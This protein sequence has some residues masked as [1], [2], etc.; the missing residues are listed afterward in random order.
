MNDPCK[1][2]NIKFSKTAKKSPFLLNV[3]NHSLPKPFYKLVNV[4]CQVIN[5]ASAPIGWPLF[6]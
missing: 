3:Q 6:V 1:S 2:Q 4:K 5:F